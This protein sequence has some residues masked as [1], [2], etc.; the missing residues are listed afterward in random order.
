MIMQYVKFIST[1]GSLK[2]N[3]EK[4]RSKNFKILFK[5]NYFI[6]FFFM[7]LKLENSIQVYLFLQ[8]YF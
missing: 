1:V 3:L 6:I 8:L 2:V 7:L 5:R 4:W